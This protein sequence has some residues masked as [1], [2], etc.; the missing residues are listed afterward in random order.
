[1]RTC[2]LV[3]TRIHVRMCIYI[4]LHASVYTYL[5]GK[6]DTYVLVYTQ[7][8]TRV[9][10]TYRYRNFANTVYVTV[11]RVNAYSG[12]ELAKA[13]RVYAICRPELG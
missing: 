12:G 1:M 7:V 10:K 2:V 6:N 3:C 9:P 4:Y 5:H 11:S 13:L 8:Y